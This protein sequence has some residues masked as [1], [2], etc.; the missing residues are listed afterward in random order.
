MHAAL[1]A[2]RKLPIA[3]VGLLIVEATPPADPPQT[4]KI[5]NPHS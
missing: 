1:Q 4:T 5:K 3:E 2:Q